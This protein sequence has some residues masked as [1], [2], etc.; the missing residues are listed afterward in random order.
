MDIWLGT[1]KGRLS[2]DT[3]HLSRRGHGSESG[4]SFS[5]RNVPFLYGFCG[6]LQRR[7][8]LSSLARLARLGLLDAL[9]MNL[10]LHLTG[11]TCKIFLAPPPIGVELP[12]ESGLT[13]NP[14]NPFRSELVLRSACRVWVPTLTW[15]LRDID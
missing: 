3:R 8:E 5:E 13:Q 4:S 9:T 7:C 2:R 10:R 12:P 14:L 6:L 15:L 1:V 11:G